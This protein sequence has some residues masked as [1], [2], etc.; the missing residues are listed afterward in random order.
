MW[1]DNLTRDLN[2]ESAMQAIE[3]EDDFREQQRAHETL[4][5]A[6]LANPYDSDEIA[7]DADL[8][9]EQAIKDAKAAL[10]AA[11]EFGYS[12]VVGDPK[13]QRVFD[14]AYDALHDLQALVGL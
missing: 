7:A 1:D 9:K 8:T 12:L 11:I 6:A 5:E 3:A 2:V 13:S 10:M 14:A 4:T